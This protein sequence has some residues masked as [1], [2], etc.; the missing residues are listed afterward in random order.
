[1]NSQAKTG[2]FLCQCGNAIAPL[3]DLEHLESIIK[4]NTPALYC[5]TLSNPCLTPG[6]ESII[7]AT[8]RHSLNRIIVA[9]CEGRIM[10]KKFET[11]LEPLDILKGQIDMVNLQSHV[12]SVSPL[13]P[14]EKAEKS[15]RL[16]KGAIAEM[17]ILNPTEQKQADLDGPVAIVGSGIA[18]FPAAREL[19]KAGIETLLFLETADPDQILKN[20]NRTY[21]G[22]RLLHDRLKKMVTTVLQ[23]DHVTVVEGYRLEECLGITGEYTLRLKKEDIGTKTL[24]A[25]AVI[26]ALDASLNAPGPEYGYDGKTV[27]IHSDLEDY[28]SRN[29]APKGNVVFWISDAEYSTGEFAQLSAKTAWAM[30]RHIKEC[31]PSTRVMILYNQT[32]KVPLSGSER[33]VNRKLDILWIPYDSA[34]PPTVQDHYLTF[35]NLKWSMN[36]PGIFWSCPRSGVSAAR[37]DQRP[38]PL[39]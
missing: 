28:L 13:S 7:T 11:A 5:E 2:V 32:M 8:A 34:V 35:C 33:S 6:L 38:R 37:P 19:S 26:A 31:A 36:L 29:G 21:P 23:D 30:A 22:E 20:L 9:G 39:D 14:E 24:N 12:A 17:E 15:A 3:I 1:M 10:L 27:L 25:G 4:N 18:S 16:I